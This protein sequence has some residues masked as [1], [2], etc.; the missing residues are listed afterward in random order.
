VAIAGAELSMTFDHVSVSVS[1]IEASLRFYRDVL[2]FAEL[3]RPDF[4]FPGAWLQV[5]GTPVHLTTG[6]T[7][8]GDDAPLRANDP[9]FAI[10]VRGDLDEFLDTL[11]GRG[12]R[13]Y[14]LQDSPAAERQ[15]FVMDPDGNVIEF[16][17]YAN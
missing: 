1:D 17:V 11:R 10:S 8:R 14:E 6:G 16:C 13:V 9:H 5:S 15:T 12:V 7:L 4:G 3:P 2:G